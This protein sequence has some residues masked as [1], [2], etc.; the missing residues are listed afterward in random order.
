MIIIL[1][2][3]P[4]PRSNYNILVELFGVNAQLKD[5]VNTAPRSAFKYAISKFL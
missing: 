1:V 4:Y 5:F 3:V 2:G